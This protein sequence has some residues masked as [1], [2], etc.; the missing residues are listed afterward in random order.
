MLKQLNMNLFTMCVTVLSVGVLYDCVWLLVHLAYYQ[1]LAYTLLFLTP[2]RGLS[3]FL[4]SNLY[5]VLIFDLDPWAL[6]Q[7]LD[8]FIGRLVWYDLTRTLTFG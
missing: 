6:L 4:L 8:W 7:I 1:N 3:L 5:V 2:T